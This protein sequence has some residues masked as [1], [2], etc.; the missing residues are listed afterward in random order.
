MSSTR[1]TPLLCIAALLA[2]GAAA[3]VPAR[4]ESGPL[5]ETPLNVTTGG[6]VILDVH[7][8]ADGTVGAMETLRRTPPYTE[9]LRSAVERWRFD[10]AREGERAVPTRVLV[11]G[12]TLQ[13]RLEGEPG[14]GTPPEDV[15]QGP[16]SEPFPTRIVAPVYPVRAAGGGAVLVEV[17]VGAD[18]A[19]EGATVAAGEP[20]FSSASL[21]AVQ[22][23]RFRPA[24][25]GG[26]P[27]PA[28]IEVVVSFPEPVLAVPLERP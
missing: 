10:P 26:A 25:A 13:P 8:E 21:E 3:A 23:W 5:P 14:P 17:T 6:Q 19:V 2:G 18:G 15:A 7:V 20:P 27:A 24:S 22:S 4:F 16:P 1:V 9:A 28:V 12:I 11:V